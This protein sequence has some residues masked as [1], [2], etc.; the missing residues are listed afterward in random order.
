MKQPTC[1]GRIAGRSR[2]PACRFP[3]LG[4]VLNDVAAQNA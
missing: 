2:G 4:V 1:P 3:A